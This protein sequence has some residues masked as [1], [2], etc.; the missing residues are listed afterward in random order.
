MNPTYSRKIQHLQESATI[1]ISTL[2]REL[3]AQGKNILSFS[4]GEPDFD[5][6][7]AIKEEAKKALDSG[8][9]KYTAVAGIPEL[10][11]AIVEKLKKDNGLEYTPK[12][13]LVSNGAKQSLFNV[14]Q[15]IIDE[16]DEVIIPAPYWVT[17][18][19]LVEYSGGK[20]VIIN[21]DSKN[22]LKIT[23]TQLKNAITP[24]TKAIVLTTPSN[25][26]GMV[27]S[28]NELEEINAVLKGTNIWIIAD[29]IYEKLIYDGEF[30]SVGAI[31][32]ASLE[33]TITIN[34]LSKSVAMTGW[35]MG[36][37]ACKDAKLVKMMD[38]LQSQCTSNI[39]SITQKAAIVALNGSVDKDIE[40]MRAAFKN[41]RD[42]ACER[43]GKIT[44]LT[45]LKPQGS[46]YLFININGVG[47]IK[48]N[49]KISGDSSGGFVANFDKLDSMEFCKQLLESQGVALVPGSAFG[50]EGFVRMSFACKE[51]QILEGLER[52]EKFI[53][54]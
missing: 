43:I 38:N 48:P 18:P 49:L 23:P 7:N 29:E 20:S 11:Q 13:I 36:Y 51:E 22:G 40:T 14:F 17:Y 42:I 15:A 8:F 45:V 33:R 54:S 9:T 26:T 50:A 47:A 37:L 34:G 46:F 2:A 16:G 31:D 3:K 25:P 10:K 44:G 27:Y 6:P 5:T 52:I 32:S 12:E 24:K 19:E 39:N 41:R 28:R 1:A 53:N 4:A 30:C 35:R 21:T